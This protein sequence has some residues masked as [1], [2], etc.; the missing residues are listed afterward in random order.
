MIRRCENCQHYYPGVF[1]GRCN[2]FHSGALPE[3]MACEAGFT[4]IVKEPIDKYIFAILNRQH[5][6]YVHFDKIYNAVPWEEIIDGD[7][8][9]LYEET[10]RVL[11]LR[12]DQLVKA[13]MIHHR[14]LGD[15]KPDEYHLADTETR[16]MFEEER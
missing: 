13:G 11:K 3:S 12:M 6:N 16:D 4:P 8:N 1:R 2:Y 10:I 15:M 7:V 5:N 14:K 9:Y